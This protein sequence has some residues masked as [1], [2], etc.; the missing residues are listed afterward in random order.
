MSSPSRLQQKLEA[1]SFVITSEV[2]P[3]KGSDCT[4]FVTNARELAPCVDAINVTDNQGAH[5]RISPLAASALLQREG[6]EPVF[7]LTCRDRNRLALQSDL[8]GAHALGIT[9]ILLLSGDH[10]SCGDHKG[11][12]AVFDLDSV[13]LIDTT[14]RLCH[15]E[16]LGGA[17][18]H[19]AP[20]FFIGAAAAPEAEPFDLTLFKLRKKVAAG[21]Q[22]LQTQAVFDPA[23]CMRL[24]QA[25]TPHGTKIIAGI[26]VLKSAGMARFINANIPGLTI[27]DA[28]IAELDSSPSPATTGIDIACRLAAAVR[29]FCHGIHIMPMGQNQ[30]VPAIVSAVAAD[31]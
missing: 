10:I 9:N 12:R 19:G 23:A 7:Q 14:A 1:S 5:M 21:A 3:P 29:P 13:Q 26:L 2:W 6:I 27:P 30:V 8:L 18:L 20:T 31:K 4:A 22:F 15:G 24:H 16:D 28:I 17:T 25:M 11:A